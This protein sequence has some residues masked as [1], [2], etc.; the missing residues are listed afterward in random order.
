MGGENCVR[1]LGV[2]L[3]FYLLKRVSLHFE[4]FCAFKWWLTKSPS[5]VMIV[6]RTT[7]FNIRLSKD[8]KLK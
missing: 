4:T 1:V 6:Y 5:R 7:L 8:V 3:E 2:V